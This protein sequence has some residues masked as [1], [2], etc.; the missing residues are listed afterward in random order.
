MSL[1]SNQE[2]YLRVTEF[3]KSKYQD[4]EKY[5]MEWNPKKM[6]P[7]DNEL[8]VTTEAS[9]GALVSLISGDTKEIKG[10]N[11]FNGNALSKGK[12]AV[13]DGIAFGYVVADE[14]SVP[15]TLT[16]DY[17]KVPNYL[18]FANLKLSQDSQSLIDLP[19]GNIIDNR[20]EAGIFKDMGSMVLVEDVSAIDLYI[21]YPKNLKATIPTGKKLFV[22]VR[23]NGMTTY[24]MRAA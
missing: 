9:V 4:N 14:D 3:L 23:L 21:D 18:R 6:K 2:K 5:Q 12:I 19:I 22:S 13:I 7:M 20:N 11:N 8:Y 1:L 10:L 15:H 24:G 17:R 16:F